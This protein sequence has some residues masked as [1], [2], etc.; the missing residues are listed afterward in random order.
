M[1]EV[2]DRAQKAST[3]ERDIATVASIDAITNI[4][5]VVCGLTGMGFAAVARV[6]ETTWTA[7]AVRDDVGF[8]LRAGGELP[9][10]TTLC[11]EIRDSRTPVV[12][13]NVADDPVYAGH[14]TP[15]TYGLQSY[16]SFPIIRANGEMFGTLCAIDPLP[17]VVSAPETLATFELFA[18]LIAF[19]LDAADKLAAT[20]AA[21]IDADEAAVLRDQFIAVLGHDLR[22]PLASIQ[23]GA[24]LLKSTRLSD[25]DAMIVQ[26]I[27]DSGGRMGRL[28]DD[29]LDFARG[30]LGGG[31][32][33]VRQPA[34]ELRTVIEQVVQEL[35]TAWPGR[36]IIS[37]VDVTRPVACDPDRVAQLLSN[38][39]ANAL[40]HGAADGAVHVHALSGAGVFELSVTNGGEPI[41]EDALPQL[42]QPFSRPRKEGP[43]AGLG[44][45]LYIASQIATGH[46]GT[47]EADSTAARTRFR[48][49]MPA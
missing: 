4:L 42:F 29:V 32:P 41:P 20:E 22:N 45:G 9:L 18:Q 12:I 37:E 40:T 39:V 36:S 11:D 19:H 49:V 43:Q 26:Q 1:A 27:Q 35:R 33:L 25:R 21:L 34:A 16:I 23:A 30:R 8:G 15:A 2:G 6:T 10:K 14:H 44:L 17:H 7:C 28:I 13:D 38:L 47:L 48:F 5:N 3:I 24:S 46:A 31:V